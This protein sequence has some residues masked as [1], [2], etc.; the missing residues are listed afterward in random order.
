MDGIS[1]ATIT[2]KGTVSMMNSGLNQY[3]NYLR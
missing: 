1:G 3:K 2:S